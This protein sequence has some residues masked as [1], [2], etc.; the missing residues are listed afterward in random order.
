MKELSVVSRDTKLEQTQQIYQDYYTMVNT[1]FGKIHGYQDITVFSG[2][3]QCFPT[4]KILRNVNISSNSNYL[5][6]YE[7]ICFNKSK[8]EYELSRIELN[9]QIENNQFLQYPNNPNNQFGPFMQAV[10]ND[11]N[12]FSQTPGAY[13]R[14]N[15]EI[16]LYPMELNG[17]FHNQL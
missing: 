5:S 7:E 4:I 1:I 9:F 8:T 10:I 14:I 2:T 16:N 13:I 17:V 3:S 6:E 12:K 11:M 15:N